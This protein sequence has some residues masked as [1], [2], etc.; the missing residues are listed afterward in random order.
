MSMTFE[1][2]AVALPLVEAGSIRAIAVTSEA[3]N[4][5]LPGVPTLSETIADFVS[6]SFTG[7]VAPAGA[8]PAIIAKLNAA[9]N[10]SLKAPEMR[11]ALDK[12]S[13][14]VK[15][16]SPQEFAAFLATERE[17]WAGVAKAAH[18]SLDLRWT[19]MRNSV[20]VHGAQRC[21]IHREP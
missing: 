17:K 14:D 13:V 15:A 2:P 1:N 7:M 9:I 20:R 4:P 18:I 3:R 12:L 21:D 6:V 5:R 8:A 10:E 11:T 16:G 19:V